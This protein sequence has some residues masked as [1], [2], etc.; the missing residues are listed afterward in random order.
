MTAS[1]NKQGIVR[2]LLEFEQI[3][4]SYGPSNSLPPTQGQSVKQIVSVL[5]VLFSPLSATSSHLVL[6]ARSCLCHLIPI[7]KILPYLP[8]TWWQINLP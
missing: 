8:Y 2:D 5:P 6:R 4:E 3:K 1:L 7:V